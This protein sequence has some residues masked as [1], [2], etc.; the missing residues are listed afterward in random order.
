MIWNPWI[1]L[2]F[3]V[4]VGLAVGG[5]YFNGR[6]DGVKLTDA[7]W[8]ER[9]NKELTDANAE[10]VRLADLNKTIGEAHAK[11]IAEAAETLN[12]ARVKAEARRLRDVRA[13]LDGSSMGLRIPAAVCKT[14]NDAA[15]GAGTSAPGSDAETGIRL[16][17]EVEANL[18]EL[19]HDANAT[20]DAL[21][22]AQ[23]IIVA[24]RKACG[25]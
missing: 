21:R 19:A 12:T 24:D 2:V 4:S 17:R 3:V 6:A 18:F 10:I 16:P 9:E 7:K 11:S 1:I 20:A 25:Q 22:A 8:Q 14:Y 5:A 13:A 15:T 23:E